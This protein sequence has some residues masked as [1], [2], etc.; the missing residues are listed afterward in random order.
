MLII[1]EIEE[2]I[3]SMP[4]GNELS[5]KWFKTELSKQYNRTAEK[6]MPSD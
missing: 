3:K 2:F 6:Y 5:T 4:L 1:V